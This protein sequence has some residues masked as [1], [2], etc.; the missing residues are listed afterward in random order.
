M[1][2]TSLDWRTTSRKA[3]DP[4]TKKPNPKEGVEEARAAHLV[5]AKLKARK[6]N[7]YSVPYMKDGST[8]R[9]PTSEEPGGKN[10]EI[11]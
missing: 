4:T 10:E 1:N 6:N 11:Q 3:Y 8:E 9:E 2:T 5:V 7:R